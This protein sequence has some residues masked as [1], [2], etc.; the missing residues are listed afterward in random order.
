MDI[1]LFDELQKRIP[2]FNQGI[3]DGMA[4]RGL[5]NAKELIDQT[6]ACAENS[7]PS[8][9]EYNGSTICSPQEA[10]SVMSSSLT[11]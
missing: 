11:R 1:E 3:L 4:Y 10:Y 2:V 8:D 5:D 9:F 7:Y 6:I